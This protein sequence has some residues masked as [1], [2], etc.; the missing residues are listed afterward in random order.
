M[1]LHANLASQFP[2]NDLS[3]TCVNWT[4]YYLNYMLLML[5]HFRTCISDRNKE[6]YKQNVYSRFIYFGVRN[7]FAQK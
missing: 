2:G 5:Y 3:R 7:S 4:Q 1:Y 6:K